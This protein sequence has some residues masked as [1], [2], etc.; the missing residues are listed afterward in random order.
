MPILMPALVTITP[1]TTTTTIPC[2]T[3][4][5]TEMT[6]NYWHWMSIKL[7]LRSHLRLNNLRPILAIFITIMA[8]RILPIGAIIIKISMEV[9]MVL[10]VV[11]TT[12]MMLLVVVVVDTTMITSTIHFP[13]VDHSKTR[14]LRHSKAAIMT[15]MLQRLVIVILIILITM[16]GVEAG[17]APR[18]VRATPISL[19][20]IRMVLRDIMDTTAI[21]TIMVGSMAARLLTMET[22]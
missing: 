8:R 22:T 21:I 4:L 5:K 1:A 14:F 6:M 16:L 7:S 11:I 10:M 15:P 18:L 13:M 2:W 20:G 12:I 19:G 9:A 17:E 3:N